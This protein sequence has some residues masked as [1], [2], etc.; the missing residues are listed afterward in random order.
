MARS[1]EHQGLQIAV[2][3]FVILTIVLSITTFMFFKESEE[4]SKKSVEDS[5]KASKAAN[6]LRAVLDEI[7]Q[8]KTMIGADNS[9]TVDKVT[10]DFNTSMDDFASAL[11]LTDR[12]YRGALATLKENFIKADEER[13]QE[14]VELTAMRTRIDEIEANTDSLVKAQK[15]E[16][17]AAAQRLIDAQ[18]EF[19]KQDEDHVKE[20]E[21]LASQKKALDE[22]IVTI[23]ADHAAKVKD[24]LTD[25]S[26]LTQVNDAQGEKIKDIQNESFEVA[27]GEI[28][29]INQT[30]GTV[31]INLGRADALPTQLGFSVWG[32]D[33]NGV[34]RNDVKAKIEVVQILGEHLAEARILQDSISDPIVPGDQIYTPLWHPGRAERFALAGFMDF[35]GDELSDAEMIKSLITLRGSLIDA[36]VTEDGKIAGPGL[37]MNTRYLIIGKPP[38][39]APDK[40]FTQI[41][42]EAKLLGVEVITMEKFLDHMGWKDPNRVIEFGRSVDAKDFPP[43][44]TDKTRPH[45]SHGTATSELFKK[46]NPRDLQKT[47]KKESAYP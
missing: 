30:T 19:K 45:K 47:K 6:D 5:A 28:R 23:Q 22:Q 29:W 38:K 26:K 36:E 2:I 24:Y 43:Y 4:A 25:I 34:A 8:L 27:D 12:N 3:I 15:D 46:R 40:G 11:P 1:G 18:N 31:W 37:T 41:Q 9:D 33:E 21:N 10:A 44:T 16:A 39:T 20:R 17:M 13:K 14:R 32:H 42:R 35:N 7:A